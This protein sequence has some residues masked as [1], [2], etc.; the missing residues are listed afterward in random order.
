MRCRDGSISSGTLK[1]FDMLVTFFNKYRI[2]ALS[3][4]TLDKVSIVLD[5]A[6]IVNQRRVLNGIRAHNDEYY[7]YDVKYYP[8]ARK[9]LKGVIDKNR[10][11]SVQFDIAQETYA[12]LHRWKST[13][14]DTIRCCRSISNENHRFAYPTLSHLRSHAIVT[15]R[16]FFD[17]YRNNLWNSTLFYRFRSKFIDLHTPSCLLFEK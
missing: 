14:I 16:L 4:N 8:Q 12:K 3:S 17:R 7:Y 5:L 10:R 11:Q 15:F 6:S 13:S 1:Y 2:I 9:P